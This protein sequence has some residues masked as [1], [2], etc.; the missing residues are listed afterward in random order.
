M[1]GASLPLDPVQ[2]TNFADDTSPPDAYSY[3]CEVACN[4]M[5][6]EAVTRG[7]AD[8]VTIML[9]ALQ[10]SWTCAVLL[11]VDRMMQVL[12][13]VCHIVWLIYTASCRD[14][15]DAMLAFIA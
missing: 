9:V 3:R 2:S 15:Y 6:V 1:V 10:P 8:N 4:R 13:E 11:T 7:C 14:E 5:A 12:T